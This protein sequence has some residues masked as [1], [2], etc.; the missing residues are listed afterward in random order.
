MVANQQQERNATR[1]LPRARDCVPVAESRALFDEPQPP[2]LSAGGGGV[3]GL[4][5]RADHHADFLN[6]GGQYL[7]DENTQRRLGGAVPVHQGLQ[8]KCPLSLASGGDDGFLDVHDF[9][10]FRCC[11]RRHERCKMPPHSQLRAPY[12]TITSDLA[13]GRAY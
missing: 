5:S 2:T 1:K 10:A 4:V 12:E 6:T 9:K 7:L 8:R 11:A 13:V 3:G